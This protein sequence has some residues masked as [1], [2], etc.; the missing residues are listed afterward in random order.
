MKPEE[1]KV[2]II[3]NSV[4]LAI[5]LVGLGYCL[6]EAIGDNAPWTG[7]W[8]FGILAIL[9][10]GLIIARVLIHKNNRK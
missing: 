6:R 10:I 2:H 5:C 8:I 3:L 1:I 7:V 9:F 4:S